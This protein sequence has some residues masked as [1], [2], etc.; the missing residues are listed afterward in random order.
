MR[1]HHTLE[2]VD[3]IDFQ[4]L[5]EADFIVN[6]DEKNITLEKGEEQKAIDKNFITET[7]TKLIS[8]M[9]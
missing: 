8:G 2:K 7:G 5:W 9:F 3:G 1:H 6:I 4:V